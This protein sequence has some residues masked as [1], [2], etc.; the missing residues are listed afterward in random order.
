[1]MSQHTAADR[2][3]WQLEDAQDGGHRAWQGD[4]FEEPTFREL[5]E[6]YQARAR[7]SS[8]KETTISGEDS[9]LRHALEWL[10]RE[11]IL[12]P[13]TA[14][15][16]AYLEYRMS[17]ECR[18]A[19]GKAGRIT[20][21]SADSHKAVLQRV[22]VACRNIPKK[23]WHMVPNPLAAS[24]LGRC[25]DGRDP[26]RSMAEPYVTYPA[27]LAT[28]PDP[29]AKAFIAVQRWHGLRLQEVLAI[30]LPGSRMEREDPF[31]GGRVL[32]LAAGTLR[33][34]RQRSRDVALAHEKLKTEFSRATIALAPEP[35][36]LLR[37]ALTWRSA[38]AVNPDVHWKKRNGA[39]A[40][41]WVFPYFKHHLEDLLELHRQIAPADFR[42][43]VRGVDGADGWHVYRHTFATEH[44]RNV[45]AGVM[46]KEALHKALRHRDPKT[47]D[48]YIRA[49]NVEV[50]G[51][52]G[53]Q[54]SWRRQE[55]LQ[56]QA[57]RER[58]GKGL[59][60]VK[61]KK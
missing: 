8:K 20:P 39:A 44:Y 3:R 42:V 9:Y 35:M 4:L 27:L 58:S 55:Q 28:M 10:E 2:A 23:G 15:W 33:I 21:H 30:P 6:W 47:T 43:R 40:Q 36:R 32:D 49:L 38:Q 41:A 7:P 18:L 46:T 34:E 31:F 50:V 26:A 56:E 19:D 1:M 57:M 61:E 14:D 45:L 29:L 11:G 24:L 13:T 5:A 37:E 12:R 17:P 51:D 48:A 60:L 54:E 52:Q 59:I 16:K 25:A 53:M 22:Y